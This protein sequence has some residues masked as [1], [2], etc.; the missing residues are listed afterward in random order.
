MLHKINPEEIGSFGQPMSEAISACVH[1]GFCLPTCPTYRQLGQEMDSPRGRIYLMKEVL[2][3]DLAPAE[4]RAPIDRCLGCLACVSACP[5]GVAYENLISPYRALH[6]NDLEKP[7]AERARRR[8]LMAVLPHPFRF[9]LAVRVGNFFRFLHRFAPARMRP[10]LRLL[11]KEL[12]PADSLPA[13]NPAVGPRR[14]RVALLTGCVQRV[15]SPSINRATVEVLTRN[16]VEV[17]IPPRQ[18]CC[19][20]LAWH[21]GEADEA[22]ARARKILDTFPKDVD[23]VIVNAAGCGSAM[24]EYPLILRGGEGEGRAAGFSERVM[25]ISVFLDRLGIVPPPPLARPRR[26]AYHDACHLCHGQRVRE[27]PRK[28]LRA[29]PGLTLVELNDGEQCC[30]SAGTYNIDQPELAAKLGA[31]K[32]AVI[33]NAGCDVVATGNIGCLMQIQS[34]LTPSPIPVMHTIELLAEAYRTTEEPDSC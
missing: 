23:A 9:R 26:V 10:M 8:L 31:E 20:A 19:G 3:G 25:D 17:V 7:F 28:L 29:I 34:H 14:A 11:P 33:R 1:C 22:A 27:P 15:L 16:G 12:P 18:S 21:V 13:V 30:G 2:E 5:S 32:A 4:A 24:R 6:T